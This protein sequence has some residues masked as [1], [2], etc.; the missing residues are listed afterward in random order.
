M[1]MLYYRARK[2]DE[3]IMT[4]GATYIDERGDPR[5]HPAAVESLQCWK[6]LRLMFNEVGLTPSARARLGGSGGGG[7]AKNPFLDVG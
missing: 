4:Q 6:E 3:V 5:R 7:Q 2:A 1:A